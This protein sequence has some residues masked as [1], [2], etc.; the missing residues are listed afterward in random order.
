MGGGAPLV[1]PR[2]AVTEQRGQLILLSGLRNDSFEG[3]NTGVAAMHDS[4][5]KPI[6]YVYVLSAC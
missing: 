3:F 2:S 6:S 5:P 1:T 4:L